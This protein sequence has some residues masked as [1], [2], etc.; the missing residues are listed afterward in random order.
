MEWLKVGL[1]SVEL[2][3]SSWF[4]MS[5]HVLPTA[6]QI[7]AGRA[8]LGW[9]QTELAQRAGV[10][11]RTLSAME[12]GDGRVTQESIEALRRVLLEAGVM[13][14]GSGPDEGVRRNDPSA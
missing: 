5:E 3:D 14:T 10:S 6:A 11:R 9:S 7:R 2:L 12:N 13:F 1:S 4:P 8:L